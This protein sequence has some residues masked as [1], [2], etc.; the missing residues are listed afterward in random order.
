MLKFVVYNLVIMIAGKIM[1]RYSSIKY[2]FFLASGLAF[3]L[4]KPSMGQAYDTISNWDGITQDWYVSTPGSEVVSNPAPDEVNTSENCFKVISGPGLYDYMI[5]ELA[6]PVNFDAYPRYRI[7]VL[8]PLSGGDVTLKFENHNNTFWHELVMTPVP[9]QWTDLE[10]DFSG[11]V[12]D[13]LVKMV[14]FPDFLGTTPG[15]DWYIDDVLR[16]IGELPGPLE[17][18]SDLPIVVIN[19]FG[20][21]IPDEPKITAHMGVINNGPGELNNLADPFTEYDGAIGIETRGQ[22]S[23]MFPKKSFAVETRYE[24]GENLNVPL[25]GMP[26]ENDWVFY[27]PYADKSLLRNVVSFEMGRKMDH[28]CTRSVFFELVINNDYKGVY[29][30]MEKIKRDNNRVD[31][32]TLN[33]DEISGEDLT[34]GYII[35]VDKIDPDF[36]FEADG[37]IS[38]P[39]PSYPNAKDIIFQYYYPEPDVMA[40]QQK[41][42][43][44]DFIARAEDAL[45]SSSFADS[46]EGYQKYF[47]VLSFVDIMLLNELAKEVD[48]Y[49]YSTYFH[50]EKDSDGGK[51]LAG[52]AWDFDLGYGNV[53]FWEP[54][55]YYSGWVYTDVMPF[56]WSIMYWWKRLMEDQYFKNMAKTRWD[57]LRKGPL[58]DNSIHA[59]IDSILMH[60]DGAKD[61]NFQR[62]KIMGKYVW[63]NY[64]WYGNTYADEV[65]YF[66]NFLFNRLEWMDNNLP[67]TIQVPWAGI[68]AT[69][70]TIDFTLYGDYFRR[71]RLEAGDFQ[72]NNAPG[73]VVIQDVHYLNASHC[74]LVISTDISLFQNISVTIDEKAINYWEDITSNTL[75]GQGSGDMEGALP[76]ISLYTE[77]NRLHILCDS[78]GQLPEFAEIVNLSGQVITAFKLEKKTGNIY[79]HRLNPGIYL[80]VIRTAGANVVLK[81]PVAV[82]PR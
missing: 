14:I 51:L 28:Y 10:Y 72:L 3:F 27:A 54:G 52:P 25:L 46:D 18:E 13:D 35:R 65:E 73:G 19:T 17:L 63:P 40:V 20:V 44:R 24:S 7:K 59:L 71:D 26:S 80:L 2:L 4:C 43:I 34:G 50:K 82:G 69:S 15:I 56:E 38:D 61:R 23:Q 21:P 67:G 33:P 60:T 79:T 58:N 64:N 37:W 29:T 36:D 49:R 9:G 78:P 74:Q 39:V 62:W 68:S 45:I 41:D 81:F 30:L 42:Y 55:I 48:K 6:E 1:M 8:A 66:E 12:Y 11:F 31:I 5:F 32:A 70:G 47:D 22:S 77:N 75:S 57:W 16:E 53:N 76:V